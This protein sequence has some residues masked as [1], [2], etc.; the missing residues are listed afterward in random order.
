MYKKTLVKK[1]DHVK[2]D[3]LTIVKESEKLVWKKSIFTYYNKVYG[4]TSDLN[5]LK[6][7]E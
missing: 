3:F 7:E 4:W 6:G 5:N 2:I 1:S